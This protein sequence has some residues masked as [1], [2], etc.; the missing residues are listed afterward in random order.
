M[1]SVCHL[2]LITILQGVQITGIG[3]EPFT[4]GDTVII[5]CVSDIPANEI[6]WLLGNQIVNQGHNIRRLKLTFDPVN[7]TIH[8]VTYTCVVDRSDSQSPVPTTANTTV[9]LNG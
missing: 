5:Q 1:K 8:G 6:R 7:D 2:T 4:V 3:S 9:T